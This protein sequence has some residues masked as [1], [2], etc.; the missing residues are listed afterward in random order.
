MGFGF[1]STHRAAHKPS[2]GLEQAQPGDLQR[3][4]RKQF[5]SIAYF[6]LA[7]KINA[8]KWTICSEITCLP[9]NSGTQ[10]EIF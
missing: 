6:A 7:S 3:I 2:S 5:T 9:L 10:E 8:M 4:Q 1:R